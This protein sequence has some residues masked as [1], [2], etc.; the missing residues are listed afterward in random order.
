MV[1]DHNIFDDGVVTVLL[2]LPPVQTGAPP[3]IITTLAAMTYA[4]HS[5]KLD[6]FKIGIT[7]LE[8]KGDGKELLLAALLHELEQVR[9]AETES[10]WPGLEDAESNYFS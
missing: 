1:V 10:S 4:I 9:V 2:A 6:A 5:S 7:F 3:K 8:F